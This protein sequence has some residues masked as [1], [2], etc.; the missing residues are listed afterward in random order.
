M[1]LTCHKSLSE[2]KK[3]MIV[4]DL[5]FFRPP[6]IKRLNKEENNITI[7]EYNLNDGKK[8]IRETNGGICDIENAFSSFCTTEMNTTIDS[9]LNLRSCFYECF[10]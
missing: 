7:N 9:Q 4:L 5:Y 3:R 8:L 1:S 10:F 6:A 2:F